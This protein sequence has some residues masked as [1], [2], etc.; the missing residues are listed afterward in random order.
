VRL[1]LEYA[2]T[3]D[4]VQWQTQH[5]AGL[6]P[7]RFPYGL[8]WLERH[9]FELYASPPADGVAAFLDGVGRRA[10]GGFEFVEAMRS[11]ARRSCDAAL[12]WDERTGVPAALR[13]RL[14]GE[15]DAVFGVIWWTEPDAPIGRRGRML[16]KKALQKAAGVWAMSTAQL[17]VLERDWGVDAQRLHLLHMG[18]D[19]D[20]WHA[21]EARQEPNLVVGA[22]NDRHRDHPLLVEAMTRLR[23]RRPEVRLELVTHQRVSV[24]PELGKR[25]PHLTHPE[26]RELYGRA[27]VV[28]VALKPNFHLSGLSVMLEAMACSC[29]VVVTDSPGLSDYLR[30]GETGLVVPVGN[31]E[32]LAKAV[33]ELLVDP[34]RARALAEAGR[35]FVSAFS[36]T[37]QAATLG[38]IIRDSCR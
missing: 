9:G 8:D 33:E 31:A 32:A 37:A 23:R 24:L 34:D 3:L 17:G 11:R 30:N 25:H 38:R 27:S 2:H 1:H 7:D 28:A 10:T 26:M 36:T 12:C 6:V 21:N 5:A 14:P 19:A 15:P 13:S 4:A 18:I 16:A 35:E 20:F 22:G 29:P